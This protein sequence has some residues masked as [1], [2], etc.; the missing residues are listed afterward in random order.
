[1]IFL[2][3]IVSID[4]FYQFLRLPCGGASSAPGGGEGGIRPCFY[5]AHFYNRFFVWLLNIH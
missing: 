2:V 5:F 3:V 4:T 1:M